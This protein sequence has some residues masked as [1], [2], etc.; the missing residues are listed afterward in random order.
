M[1]LLTYGGAVH[2]LVG[3][4]EGREAAAA[5]AAPL[6]SCAE[7]SMPP[8]DGYSAPGASRKALIRGSLL[9]RPSLPPMPALALAPLV[10]EAATSG[11]DS[12][13]MDA[14]SSSLCGASA[15]GAAALKRV[16]PPL[17]DP[18]RNFSGDPEELRTSIPA[19][20]SCRDQTGMQGMPCVRGQ[21][22]GA[23]GNSSHQSILA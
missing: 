8:Q 9:E 17:L 23:T 5:V 22:R 21:G 6:E 19:A 15:G 3:G 20:V 13:G 4:G 16:R 18:T 14:A 7:S 1:P 12:S 10:V 11:L 2:G